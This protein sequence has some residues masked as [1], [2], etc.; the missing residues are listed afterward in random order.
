MPAETNV[1]LNHKPVLF[2]PPTAAVDHL[3]FLLLLLTV[4]LKLPP[5]RDSVHG[6][7]GGGGRRPRGQGG[8]RGDGGPRWTHCKQIK[9]GRCESVWDEFLLLV[10]APPEKRKNASN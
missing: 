1:A 9:C 8:G 4:E 5:L 7:G 3:H 2:V 10:S 6:R